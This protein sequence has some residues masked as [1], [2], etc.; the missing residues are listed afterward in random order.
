[1]RE[2]PLR[3]LILGGHIPVHIA[4]IMDGN[5]RWAR[6]R[7]LPRF[8]GHAAGMK[9]VRE[10]VEGAIEA[11]VEI[12]TL[13]AFSQENWNRPAPEISALMTL[14]ERYLIQERK[15]L[16]ERGVQV[17]IFGDLERLPRRQ[18]GAITEMERATS[19]GRRLRLNLMISYSGRSELLR[20]ASRLIEQV[21]SGTLDP[22]TIDETTLAGELYTAGMPDPDLLIRTSGEQRISNFMLWQ[23]AY[24]ELFLSPVLWPDFN[25]EHLFEAIHDYQKR[26]RRFGRVTAV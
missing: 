16:V 4:I 10:V 5:G 24:T 22:D 8:R 19:G 7:M 17:R 15:E 25:R 6:A 12:L 3:T 9:A 20:A 1:M 11:G 13:Y 21:R 14:L 18:R 2:D 23:L 26:E